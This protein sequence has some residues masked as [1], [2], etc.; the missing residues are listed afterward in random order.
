MNK[1]I[2]KFLK[3]IVFMENMNR[4]IEN[5]LLSKNSNKAENQSA[6]EDMHRSI[7]GSEYSGRA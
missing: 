2:E 1:I 7:D 5:K 4:F 6:L 3:L